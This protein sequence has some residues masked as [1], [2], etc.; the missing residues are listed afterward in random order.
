MLRG[1]EP[2]LENDLTRNF[3]GFFC[4]VFAG[5]DRTSSPVNHTLD[6]RGNEKSA[7]AVTCKIIELLGRMILLV[8]F[9]LFVGLL[10]IATNERTSI[11]NL[12]SYCDRKFVK[13]TFN[14]VGLQSDAVHAL[15]ATRQPGVFHSAS[16]RG[17]TK[18]I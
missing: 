11:A 9:S 6:T 14:E 17:T 4:S 15:M 18:C 13:L 3:G 1:I 10:V 7:S 12:S 2:P 5:N 8:N 16:M